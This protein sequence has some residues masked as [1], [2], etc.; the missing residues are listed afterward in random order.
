MT[1]IY[2]SK[3][4]RSNYNS[5]AI[6][7]DSSCIYAIQVCDSCSGETDGTGIIVNGDLNDNGICDSEEVLGCTDELAINYDLDAN[8]DDGSCIIPGCTDPASASDQ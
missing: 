4:V 5:N 2:I 1:I 7:S 3:S 8:V 6:K